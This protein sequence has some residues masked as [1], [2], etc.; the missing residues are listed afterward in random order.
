MFVVIAIA[1]C[2]GAEI[3]F[4]LS[5]NLHTYSKVGDIGST[6]ISPMERKECSEPEVQRKLA[7]A[8]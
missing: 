3:T 6:G 2:G 8:G 1:I 7:S 4:P 5:F